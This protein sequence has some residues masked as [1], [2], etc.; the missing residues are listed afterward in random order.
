[1][2]THICLPFRPLSD[3][4]PICSPSF[5]LSHGKQHGTYLRVPRSGP[6]QKELA[7]TAKEPPNSREADSLSRHHE[8]PVCSEWPRLCHGCSVSPG[9]SLPLYLL[10]AG[11]SGC[12]ESCTAFPKTQ[13]LLQSRF[14][15]LNLTKVGRM[16]TREKQEVAGADEQVFTGQEILW[17]ILWPHGFIP[18]L[19]SLP[20]CGAGKALLPDNTLCHLV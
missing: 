12:H 5:S 8:A 2:C 20:S 3:F 17:Q 16:H 18:R 10:P 11:P 9:T 7:L 14:S 1:M 4:L 13:D 15:G 19:P 6:L